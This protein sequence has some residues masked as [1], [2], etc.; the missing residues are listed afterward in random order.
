MLC[1]VLSKVDFGSLSLEFFSPYMNSRGILF[2]KIVVLNNDC[3]SLG[4]VF[5]LPDTLF[6]SLEADN[7]RIAELSPGT[8]KGKSD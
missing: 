6:T 4:M 8:F 5:S 1:R 2:K 7:R 3:I